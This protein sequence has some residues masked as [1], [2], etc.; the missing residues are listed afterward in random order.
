MTLPDWAHAWGAPPVHARLRSTAA[1][2]VVEE[3]LGFEPD[4]EGEHCWIWVEKENLNTNDAA[5]R[6]ARF[7][8]L[9]EA[10]VSY[11]GMKDRQAVTRQ[12]FSLH[13][14]GRTVD[15]DQW[16]DPLLR[17][18]RIERHSR[19]LRRGTHRGNRFTL[20]L[21]GIEGAVDQLAARFELVAEKGVPN[22]FGPQRFGRDG[23]NI[24]AA[25]C[26][27]EEGRPRR[28]R[29][30]QSLWLSTLRSLLF[31]EVLSAR[32]RDGSWQ[33]ALSGELFVL[34]GSNSV[35]GAEVDAAIVARLASGD[36]HPSGPLVGKAGRTMPTAQAA[37]LETAVLSPHSV[38]I[39]GLTNAGLNAERRPLRLHPTDWATEQV[40]TDVWRLHFTLPR[41][42]FA[43]S[44]VRELAVVSGVG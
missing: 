5:R 29:H 3:V 22:Y 32:V 7:A 21:R 41:G 35:F 1:D 26:W 12:W 31:N 13:L 27:L 40:D 20:V 25:R 44:V 43:T 6:L 8:G 36:I 23:G 24:E 33:A 11:A 14:L 18:L 10:D 34:D 37:A 17:L 39:T 38:M 30:L 16:R 19:K 28:A 2:F 15:W 4:G 42:C 9:R